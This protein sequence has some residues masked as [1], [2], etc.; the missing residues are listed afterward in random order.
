MR[1][2]KW[3]L[4]GLLLLSFTANAEH[5][6]VNPYDVMYA[7][8]DSLSDNGSLHPD[9]P[10]PPYAEGRFSNGPVAV[11]YLADDF[12]ISL[13]DYAVAGATTGRDNPDLA[14]TPL[15]NTGVLSQVESYVSSSVVADP[16]ALYFLMAG[17]ND[18]LNALTFPTSNPQKVIQATINE[19]VNN[20]VSEVKTLHKIGANY[21]IV[22]NLPD[23]GLTPNVQALGPKAQAIATYASITFN[24]K[25]A[26]RLPQYVKQFDTYSN[27]QNLINNP[28]AFKLTNVTAPCFD[29]VSMCAE[30]D[31]YLYWDDLHP[32][33]AV[34]KIE[35]QKLFEL[36]NIYGHH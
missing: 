20:I 28:A 23:L 29:G 6:N 15:A 25:L 10:P 27:F 14:G 31:K 22:A 5:R 7:F 35:G 11:E 2:S 13:I 34:H 26:F 18:L 1:I 32:T 3:F 21:I 24:K 17:N 33:T 19:A 4:V 36:S 8:G 12:G 30:P 9:F 16:N